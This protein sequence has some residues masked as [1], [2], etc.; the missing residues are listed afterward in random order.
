MEQT[1]EV[2]VAGGF[3]DRLKTVRRVRGWSAQRLADECGVSRSVIANIENGR[4]R[5]VTV[6]ELVAFVAALRVPV[7]VL[8]PRLSDIAKLVS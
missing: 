3:P 5:D 6:D 2:P 1:M 4:K 8:E 7:S